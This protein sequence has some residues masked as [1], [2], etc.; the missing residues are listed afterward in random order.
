MN[1]LHSPQTAEGQ[2]SVNAPIDVD[3][4]GDQAFFV[5]LKTAQGVYEKNTML[6]VLMGRQVIAM[7][8]T[9]LAGVDQ[10]GV[11]AGLTELAKQL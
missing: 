3:G 7:T 4:V 8:A 11:Q 10:A 5:K 1:Q 2:A 6:Y 9:R